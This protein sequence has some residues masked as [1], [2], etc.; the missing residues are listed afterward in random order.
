M[1]ASSSQPILAQILN[2]SSPAEHITALRALKN[3]II[4]HQQ[5]KEA[6]VGLGALDSIARASASQENR[7][8]TKSGHEPARV[9]DSLS[10]E[11]TLRLQALSILG[12]LAYGKQSSSHIK[13]CYTAKGYQV[14][15]RSLHHYTMRLLCLRYSRTSVRPPTRRNWSRQHCKLCPI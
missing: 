11:E 1:E 7:Q 4:G 12:S 3:D 14:D 2:P 6:W 10:E 13:L 9:A 5:R 8:A 15:R